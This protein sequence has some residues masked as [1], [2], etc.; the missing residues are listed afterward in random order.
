MNILY[1]TNSSTYNA[2]TV[3]DYDSSFSLYSKNIIYYFDIAYHSLN[4]DIDCFDA[5]IFSYA[6]A[7]SCGHISKS[8]SEKMKNFSGK[9]IFFLQDEYTNFIRHRKNIIQFGVDAIVTVMPKNIWPD[10][11]GI[12]E[13][14]DKLPKLQVL[15]GYI[16]EYLKFKFA[17]RLPLAERKW[18][19]G[20]R[21][22][23]LPPIFG[24]LPREKYEIGVSMKKLCEQ[25][26]LPHNIEVTEEKRIYGKAWPEFIRNCRLM[27]GT[28]SGCNVF[29]FTGEIKNK[30]SEYE[31]NH[32]NADFWEIHKCCIGD[33]D[34]QICTNQISPRIFEGISL[35]TGHILYEGNYSGIIEPWKHYIPLKKD[36]SNIDEVFEAAADIDFVE[37]MICKS[38][39]D[40]VASDKYS[41]KQFIKEID[42]FIDSLYLNIPNI[43][44]KPLP[45]EISLKVKQKISQMLSPAELE[46]LQ[47]MEEKR[48]KQLTCQYTGK[49]ILA[50]GAGEAFKKYKNLFNLSHFIAIVVDDFFY[51]G[52]GHTYEGIPIINMDQAKTLVHRVDAG[53]VFSRSKW[54][55]AMSGKMADLFCDNKPAEVC[56]LYA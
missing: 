8:L 48:I 39:E 46:K 19:I 7:A 37:G 55:F 33:A 41:Y 26:C 11:Y 36:Y 3:Y 5:I 4:I 24:K 20:Y 34:G 27:L 13:A 9:K 2:N 53:I 31:R 29:D 52:S 30:I 6:F 23:T 38:Y 22:R 35:G 15:T 45:A 40:I 56:T 17:S 54:A 43:P 16:P 32:P 44:E 1:I 18:T 47:M 25:R 50:Y 28:E 51:E 12:D 42:D 49:T 14:I 10:I 21:A